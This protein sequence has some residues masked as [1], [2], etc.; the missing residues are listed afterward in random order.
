MPLERRRSFGFVS[1]VALASASLAACDDG[2]STTNAGGASSSTGATTTDATSTS[3]S[4]TTSASSG[5][6]GMA[7]KPLFYSDGTRLTANEV[8]YGAGATQFLSWHDATLDIDCSFQTFTTGDIACIPSSGDASTYFGDAGCTAPLMAAFDPDGCLQVK[9]ATIAAGAPSCDTPNPQGAPGSAAFGGVRAVTTKFTGA[10]V[11]VKA[12]ASCVAQ[13]APPTFT[14]YETGGVV[15]LSTFVQA[16]VEMEPRGA[17]MSEAVL[18]GSDGSW[19]IRRP[20]SGESPCA[21]RSVALA[22][23][24]VQACLPI[25]SGAIDHTSVFTDASCSMAYGQ[26]LALSKAELCKDPAF[27]VD[28]VVDSN[29]CTTSESLLAPGAAATL[30]PLFTG[31][32]VTCSP[33]STGMNEAWSA[34]APLDPLATFGAP[35]AQE[36]G[37]G[38]I[39]AAFYGTAADEALAS[40]YAFVDTMTTARCSAVRFDDQSVRCVDVSVATASAFSDAAC[41]EPVAVHTSSVC[42]PAPAPT[43]ALAPSAS[44]C[45]SVRTAS[46]ISKLIPY[47]GPTFTKSLGGCSAFTPPA[48]AQLFALDA[49][50]DVSTYAS[51]TLVTH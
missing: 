39:H 35:L 5:T 42:A 18:V 30:P 26:P 41:T 28:K 8:D 6:G 20:F 51:A 10:T 11:Y 47:A 36:L 45:S 34:T 16:T 14:L 31:G 15:P 3:A 38:R 46:G 32:P 22:S 27:V 13:A 1:L 29:G 24:A 37:T 12:G 33:Y 50:V 40:P 48:G 23:G 25:F 43:L 21:L 2:A 7:P 9:Y 44:T 49:P 4:T 19:Q 17:K